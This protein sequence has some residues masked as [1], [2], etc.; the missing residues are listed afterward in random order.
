MIIDMIKRNLLKEITICRREYPV[1]C[2][3]GPRQSGKTTL[4][5][6]AFP[7]LPYVSFENPLTRDYF[8][9]DP[10]GFMHQYREGAVLDEVQHVPSL[11]S[12][13]QVHVDQNPIPGRFILTG[14]QHFGLSEQIS[15]S[16]AGRTA[17][18]ELLP[19]SIDELK[20]GEMLSAD[21][22]TALWTGAYPPIHDRNLRPDRWLSSYLATYV[23]RDVRQIAQVHNLDIFTRFLRLCA[24]SAGQLFNSSRLGMEC[25]V[26][27]KTVRRWM[28]ILQASYI[29]QLLPPYY[30]NFKKRIIKTPKLYFYDTGLA[31]HLLGIQNARQLEQHPLR[32]ALFENMVFSE[33]AKKQLNRGQR[34][35]LYFWRT[36]GGQEV[37]FIVEQGL[38]VHA[39]EAKSGMTVQPAMVRSL[40]NAM[41]LWEESSVQGWVVY[42]GNERNELHENVLLPWKE[43][44]SLG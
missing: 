14:S 6:D 1:I 38:E 40:K 5:Q 15:Q 11:F 26:D 44:D 2:I 16:L 7:E 20:S 43:V 25:G 24:G 13:L 31:C 42:G 4:A 28:T 34:L 12:H 3:T 39:V 35:L 29:V 10:L 21:L 36:H 30:R 9:D 32:G 41:T 37:D 17:M 23:Q 18:L 19:F 8:S 33:I 22:N 27:H